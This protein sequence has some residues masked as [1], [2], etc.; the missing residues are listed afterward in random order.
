[1]TSTITDAM[2]RELFAAAGGDIDLAS[3][4]QKAENTPAD[5]TDRELGQLDGWLTASLLAR[6]NEFTQY[7][8]STLDVSLMETTKAAINYAL[9]HPWARVWWLRA[10]RQQFHS[11]F[12]AFVDELDWRETHS[13]VNR[14]RFTD[15]D[16][17]ELAL[18]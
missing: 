16:L 8:N 14:L 15:E 10:G 4:Y 6:Q 12:L 18:E 11:S 9:G 7:K 2:Q 13:W 3:L 1:M 17:R 5:L